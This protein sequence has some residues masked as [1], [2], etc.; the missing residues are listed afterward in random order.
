MA[1]LQGVANRN[2]LYLRNQRHLW[3]NP[4]RFLFEKAAK[5]FHILN[6]FLEVL[7]F[8]R[9][10]D[11]RNSTE[12][13]GLHDLG[14]WC[15][16]DFALSDMFVPVDAGPEARLGIIQMP[17][18]KPLAANETIEMLHRS[19][20]PFLKGDVEPSFEQM[21][22]IEASEETL[23]KFRSFNYRRQ[24]L[25]FMAKASTLAG[26]YFESDPACP[27]WCRSKNRVEG[28]NDPG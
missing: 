12:F 9:F 17:G 18:G 1:E 4:F 13:R 7:S 22:G 23:G 25:K 5:H 15:K 21:G 27:S 28:G 3:L 20:E 2:L 19:P 6:V 14:E 16:P 24:M 8:G 11:F 10:E 26:G